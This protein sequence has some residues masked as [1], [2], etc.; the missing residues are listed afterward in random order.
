MKKEIL[1]SMKENEIKMNFNEKQE[2]NQMKNFFENEFVL[3]MKLI[4][5]KK[6]DFQIKILKELNFSSC[7]NENK[8]HLKIRNSRKTFDKLNLFNEIQKKFS[9]NSNENYFNL[10]LN[11]IKRKY[12]DEINEIQNYSFQ[13]F[14]FKSK[15]FFFN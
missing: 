6:N 15:I 3:L 9:I 12:F 2:E 4:D 11:E 7:L 8:F 5:Q 14:V 13:V 10:F 1:K